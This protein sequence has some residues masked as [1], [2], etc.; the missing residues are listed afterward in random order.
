MPATGVIRRSCLGAVFERILYRTRVLVPGDQI[1][2]LVNQVLVPDLVPGDVILLSSRAV[3][4]CQ[5]RLRPLASTQPGWAARRLSA[6]WSRIVPDPAFAAPQAVQAAID[7][8]GLL[9]LT[10]Q[11]L[12]QGWRSG[13][14]VA[15]ARRLGQ[16]APGLVRVGQADDLPVYH[17]QV[18]LPPT[19]PG[20][21]ADQLWKQTGYRTAIISVKQPGFVQVVG[22]S[23]GLSPDYIRMVVLDNPLGSGTQQ[24]PVALLRKRR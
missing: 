9:P 24:T 21:L 19:A 13:A 4:A 12:Q 7:E 3:A 10:W 14:G 20:Q 23:P 17:G 18:A 2:R 8:A 11:T 16:G 6:W 5:G 15:A 22:L 1:S